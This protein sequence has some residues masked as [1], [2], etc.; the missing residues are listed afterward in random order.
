MEEGGEGRGEVL[1]GGAREREGKYWGEEG[2]EGRGGV[3][4]Y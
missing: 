4:E 1:G 2:G 3:L